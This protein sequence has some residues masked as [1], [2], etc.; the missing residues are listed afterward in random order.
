[1]AQIQFSLIKKLKIGRPEHSLRLTALR[2]SPLNPRSPKSG[3][4]TSKRPLNNFFF[5][6][7]FESVYSKGYCRVTNT[8]IALS[9]H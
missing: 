4:H 8:V 7:V 5:I 1:M 2:P 9:L 6:F 3:R